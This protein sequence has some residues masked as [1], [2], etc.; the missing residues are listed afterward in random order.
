MLQ[1]AIAGGD[2]FPGRVFPCASQKPIPG[3]PIAAWLIP[4]IT[5]TANALSALIPSWESASTIAPSRIPQPPN[6][7]GSAP[8]IMTGTTNNN[9]LT[10]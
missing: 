8:A 2:Y 1:Q 10:P 9:S 5:D 6:E 3:N 7:T 4:N